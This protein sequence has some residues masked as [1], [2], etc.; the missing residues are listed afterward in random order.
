MTNREAVLQCVGFPLLESRA[1]LLTA[2]SP[3]DSSFLGFPI[4]Y[5][6]P[7]IVRCEVSVACA[8][9]TV[10]E[11]ELTHMMVAGHADIRLVS[12]IQ[13][14]LPTAVINFFGK[15]AAFYFMQTMKKQ[16]AGFQGSQYEERV[17]DKQDFYAE[18]QRRVNFYTRF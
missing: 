1:A 3:C 9:V 18:L 13:R 12:L 4:P 5:P 14:F 2:R 17:R 11:A 6:D 7:H 16:L 10:L 15:H 8:K